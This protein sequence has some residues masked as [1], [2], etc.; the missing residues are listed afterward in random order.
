[1]ESKKANDYINRLTDY[2][3]KCYSNIVS[4]KAVE[5]A[6]D[7]VSERIMLILESKSDI[8]EQLLKMLEK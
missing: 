3:D 5:I 4:R 6:L 2:G 8:K 1:M 7:E